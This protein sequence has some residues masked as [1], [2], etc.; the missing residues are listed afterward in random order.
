[1]M[2]GEGK[3]NRITTMKGDGTDMGRPLT[4]TTAAGMIGLI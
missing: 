3:N 1:M 4:L 2:K